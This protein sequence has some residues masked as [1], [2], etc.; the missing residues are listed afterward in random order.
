MT[1][2]FSKYFLSDGCTF[3]TSDGGISRNTLGH[4]LLHL[5]MLYMLGKCSEGWYYGFFF[6]VLEKVDELV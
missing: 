2:L 3:N 6:L 1:F 5:L 4:T